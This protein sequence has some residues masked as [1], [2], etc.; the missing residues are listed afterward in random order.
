M[1]TL[2]DIQTPQFQQASGK[3]TTSDEFLELV[4]YVIDELSIRGDWDGMLVPIQVCIKNGCVTWPNYVDQ[5]R[6]INSCNQSVPVR[7]QWYQFME[8]GHSQGPDSFYSSWAWRGGCIN[9]GALAQFRAP[10]YNDPYG[11]D[12]YLRVYPFAPEDVGKTIQVFGLDGN[13]QPLQTHNDDG[14][15]TDGITIEVES[16]YGSSDTVVT[17]ID[18]VVKE[19]TQSRLRLY[20]YDSVN[21]WLFDLAVY[22]AWET[23]PSYMRYQIQTGVPWN[24]STCSTCQQAIVALVKLKQI[25]VRVSTDLILIGNMRALLNGIRAA[26]SEAAGAID[27]SQ[28]QWQVAIETMNRSLENANPD[29][30]FSARNL[31]YGGRTFVQKMF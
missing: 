21:D 25:P 11:T 19:V 24:Y 23:N 13:G 18:R 1:L 16:P 7:N 26:K 27:Q 8:H 31:V 12:C 17:K 29:A 10:T 14:T 15:W 22:D 3:C 28:A 30:Q 9:T 6:A 4:N 2:A 5:V 20:A